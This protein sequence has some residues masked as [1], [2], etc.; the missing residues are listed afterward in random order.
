[1]NYYEKTLVSLK[2]VKSASAHMTALGKIRAATE[3]STLIQAIDTLVREL[4][5]GHARSK[6]KGT[7]FSIE[8]AQAPEAKALINYCQKAVGS[9]KPEWQILAE[10]NGWTPPKV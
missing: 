10:R 3:D 4:Q 7:P 6:S 5:N 9:K 1:M 8:N 2:E